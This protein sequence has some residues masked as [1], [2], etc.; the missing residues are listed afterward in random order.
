[1][2]KESWFRIIVIAVGVLTT[3]LLFFA[4]KTNIETTGEVQLR[5]TLSASVSPTEGR[6][7][8]LAPEPRLNSWIDS[9][10]TTKGSKKI[11]ILDSIIINLQ[12]RKRFAY[13]ANYADQLVSLDS[14]LNN[15]LLAGMLNQEALNLPYVQQDTSLR[16]TYAE[17][18]IRYL[19]QVTQEELSNERA[20]LALGL[21]YTQSGNPQLSM[22]G[23]LT[24]RKILE[25][26]PDNVEASFQLGIFSIQTGQFER[27]VQ[28]FERV[29]EIEPN[30]YE[31]MFELANAQYQLGNTDQAKPLL[32]SVI[33]QTADPNLRQAAN[34]L[35]N[36]LN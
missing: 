30:H 16:R 33:Q 9:L 25:I 8:P 23:I 11:R 35:L 3:G 31:A 12:A 36:Q 27:A 2:T 21:A 20:L 34:T 6:L 29:L 32:Q 4:N 26:N 17:R 13:A 24:I 10:N 18:S 7:P 19:E 28:R 22:Q 15:I 5:S 1:M 14:S